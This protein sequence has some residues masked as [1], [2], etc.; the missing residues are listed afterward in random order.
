ML[1]RPGRWIHLAFIVLALLALQRGALAEAL[2]FKATAAGGETLDEGSGGGNPFASSLLELLSQPGLLLKELPLE[3]QRRT[4]QKSRGFQSPEAPTSLMDWVI[5]PRPANERRR[6]YVIVWSDYSRA[7]PT[8]PSLPGAKRDAVLIASAFS[9]AGFDTELV[10]D[11]DGAGLR[12]KLIEIASETR[13]DDAA[14][15]YTTGH[16]VEI[17]GHGYVLP[18]DYPGAQGA[19]AVSSRAISLDALAGALKAKRI[20]LLFYGG[21]RN[22]P[23]KPKVP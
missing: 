1:Y 9:A 16:G 17:D 21:C 19:A 5:L 11:R 22:D 13:G 18:G 10:L 3:L 15:I 12:E 20:N 2:V 8:I 7:G 23:W 6:A 4:I 14:V